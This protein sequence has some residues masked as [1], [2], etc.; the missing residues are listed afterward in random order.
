MLMN[1]QFVPPFPAP[2]PALGKIVI[3]LVFKLHHIMCNA[4]YFTNVVRDAK[5][6]TVGYSVTSNDTIIA[7][8]CIILMD[9]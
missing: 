1:I 2:C 3:D 6:A 7:T 5:F 4:I 9:A 8:N